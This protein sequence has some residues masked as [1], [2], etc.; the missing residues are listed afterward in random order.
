MLQCLADLERQNTS[1]SKETQISLNPP[2]LHISSRVFNGN[3]PN[4]WHVNVSDACLAVKARE[5][6][7]AKVFAKVTSH[8][9][10]WTLLDGLFCSFA[11]PAERLA[12]LELRAFHK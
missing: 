7:H 10:C 6:V 5:V 8:S 12:I 9:M 3:N 2:I 11:V 1:P 4:T